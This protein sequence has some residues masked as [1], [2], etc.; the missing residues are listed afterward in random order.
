[1]NNENKKSGLYFALELLIYGVLVSLYL[2][3][4]I[5]FFEGWIVQTYHTSGRLYALLSLL[6]IVAQGLILDAVT[7]S[8]LQSV[9]PKWK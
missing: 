2:F 1:V 7:R 6:L 4:I 9:H 8:V 3:L 5:H